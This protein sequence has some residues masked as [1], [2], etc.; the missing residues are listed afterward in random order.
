MAE[1]PGDPVALGLVAANA[2]IL[3]ALAE[4]ASRASDGVTVWS[5]DGYVMRTHPDLIE[6]IEGLARGLPGGLRMVYGAA[7]LVDAGDRINVVA[8]GTSTVWLR[9]EAGDGKPLAGLDG[10]VEVGAWGEDLRGRVQ[11]AAAAIG[12]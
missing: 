9:G 3:A 1:T 12:D 10:W 6:A 11:A 7:C 4:D 5:P 8:R 2:R